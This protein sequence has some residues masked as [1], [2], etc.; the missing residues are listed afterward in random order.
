MSVSVHVFV[1]VFLYVPAFC[2]LGWFRFAGELETWTLRILAT[3][4]VD[5]GGYECQVW[6]MVMIIIIITM[7]IIMM[8]MMILM[9]TLMM[10][11]K[12]LSKAQPVGAAWSC[13]SS[14]QNFTIINSWSSLTYNHY[15]WD[16]SIIILMIIDYHSHTLSLGALRSP[17]SRGWRIFTSYFYWTISPQR[18]FRILPPNF[19]EGFP[20]YTN[21]CWRI[22]SPNRFLRISSTNF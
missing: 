13:A 14:G 12:Q 21:F 3:R 8:I 9:M 7:M 4:I 19:I 5:S 20:P 17:T 11:G 18:F 10:A 16:A 6:Y 22:F 2:T 1:P 15:Y